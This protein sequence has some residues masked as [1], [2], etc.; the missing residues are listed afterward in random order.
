[1][2][3]FILLSAVPGAG[4]STWAEQYR[5]TN[6]NV[7]VVSSDTVRKEITGEFQ[8]FEHEDEVWER[9]FSLINEYAEK[10]EDI[11]VI[12]DS[13]NLQNIYRK[14]YVEQVKGF[15]FKILVVFKKDLEVLLRQ[16]RQ[17]SQSQI[18]PDDVLISMYKSFEEPSEE[19]ID[20]FDEYIVIY[21]WFDSSKVKRSFH[22]QK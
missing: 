22:Y 7:K 12:A 21:K 17:R 20:Y 16:N 13:T 5:L 10:N 15:D 6:E 14:K 8:N 4:K 2:R 1:M 19:I 11:T 3:T 9:Y 18:V